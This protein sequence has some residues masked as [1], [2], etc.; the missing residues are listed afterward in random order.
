VNETCGA[1]QYLYANSA[2]KFYWYSKT[3]Q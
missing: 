1:S 3:L 2:Y